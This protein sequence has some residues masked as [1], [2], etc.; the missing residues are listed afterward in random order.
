MAGVAVFTVLDEGKP[1]TVLNSNDG[2]FAVECRLDPMDAF[3]LA[4]QILGSSVKV[5]AHRA[6]SR[7]FG[8]EPP[9]PN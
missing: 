6:K 9:K 5:A 2:G 7:L 8:V 1:V 4:A 3:K